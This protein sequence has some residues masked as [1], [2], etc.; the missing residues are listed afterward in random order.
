[1]VTNTTRL[2]RLRPV[3]GPSPNVASTIHSF[4]RVPV[5]FPS[6]TPNSMDRIREVVSYAIVRATSTGCCSW[7]QVQVVIR[8]AGLLQVQ[9]LVLG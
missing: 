7:L 5:A 9:V 6:I 1:M 3:I 4:I 2:I 8:S